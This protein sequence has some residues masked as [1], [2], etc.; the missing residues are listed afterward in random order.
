MGVKVSGL[1]TSL[2]ILGPS[3][4]AM[5]NPLFITSSFKLLGPNAFLYALMVMVLADIAIYAVLFVF[6]KK[7]TRRGKRGSSKVR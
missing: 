5:L 2:M 6:F 3:A 1:L 4:G 7:K